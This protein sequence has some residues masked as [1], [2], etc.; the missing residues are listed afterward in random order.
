MPEKPFDQIKKMLASNIPK[1]LVEFL[2][3]KWEKVGDV[4]TLV[5]PEKLERYK[6]DVAEKYANVLGCKT[7]LNDIG[8]I[9]GEYRE[10]NVEILFGN[11]DTETIHK[12]GRIKYKLDPQKIMFS[13]GN[14]DERIRMGTISN[15]NEVI[16]DLFAGIGYF[17]L[18]M[19]VHSRP[20]RI[21]AVE[22]NP[23]SF[24]Y[25]CQ[26]IT[27][28]NVSSIVEPVHGDNRMIA[29]KNVADRVIMGY[30]GDTHQF[31]PIAFECLKNHCGIIHYHD[32]F[33]DDAVPNKPI[34]L[35]VDA[36]EKYDRKANLLNFK[37]VKSYAPGISHY[38]FDVKVGEK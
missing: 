23:V 7:V 34:E 20:E 17:T 4:L 21:F 18:P 13:S 16:V 31:L 35:V 19:A 5:L 6:K 15:Q 9:S 22:K 8:G 10:P 25:L 12:E 38:V 2:P 29:P 33:A 11:S 36:A 1:E 37:C 32:K 30:F 24:N 27:L 14:M 3:D 26:N 28:N